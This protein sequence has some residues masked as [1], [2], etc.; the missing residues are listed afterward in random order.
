MREGVSALTLKFREKLRTKELFQQMSTLKGKN[1]NVV[2]IGIREAKSKTF[3]QTIVI[4]K[5][6]KAMGKNTLNQQIDC[7]GPAICK[8]QSKLI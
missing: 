4:R 7:S 1:E 6:N 5:K 3:G 2:E 8:F